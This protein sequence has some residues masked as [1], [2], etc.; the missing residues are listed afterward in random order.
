MYLRG[1]RYVIDN[2]DRFFMMLAIWGFKYFE[3][4]T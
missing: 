2:A 1:M 4:G 3:V